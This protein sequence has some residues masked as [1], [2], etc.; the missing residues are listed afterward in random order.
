MAYRHASV[1]APTFASL[2]SALQSKCRSQR[3]TSNHM[4]LVQ[5]LHLT[6]GAEPSLDWGPN[7]RCAAQAAPIATGPQR[8][9]QRGPGR[10]GLI[11]AGG[12]REGGPA[13]TPQRL[14]FARSTH[15]R[16]RRQDALRQRSGCRQRS[17]SSRSTI[18][19]RRRSSSAGVSGYRLGGDAAA[20][21]AAAGVVVR[22]GVRFGLFDCRGM[23]G[24]ALPCWC[25]GQ[26][27]RIGDRPAAPWR[28]RIGACRNG[29]GTAGNPLMFSTGLLQQRPPRCLVVKAKLGVAH[30][31]RGISA[32]PRISMDLIASR[33]SPHCWHL[34]ERG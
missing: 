13:A 21:A 27:W 5:L 6:F 24:L 32:A 25:I 18:S 31:K 7:V 19:S 16:A 12:G 1:P 22:G 8:A 11:V 4:S 14:A 2:C 30:P 17:A 9:N 10:C 15:V 23:G 28:C 3:N 33:T 26:C 29:A 20:P 34:V